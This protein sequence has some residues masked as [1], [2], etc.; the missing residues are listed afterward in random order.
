MILRRLELSD[1]KAFKKSVEDWEPN[2]GFEYYRG[3]VP[4]MNYQSYLSLLSD[5]EKGVDLPEGFVSETSLFGFLADGSIVGRLSIRHEL[6]DF[7]FK[8]GGHIG[9]GV[10]PPFRK[11]GYAKE[12]LKQSLNFVR[13]LKINKALLTCDDDNVGSIKTIE[14][15]NGVLENKIN[16]KE[17]LPLKRRYW[18]EL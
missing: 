12:M 18:I 14:A 3:Y 11:N 9:Y 13:D 6:N 2:L 16:Q 7:L 17:G 15:C 4:G 5:R 8:I 10:L 1:E